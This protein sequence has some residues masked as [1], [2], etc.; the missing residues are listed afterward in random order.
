MGAFDTSFAAGGMQA[1]LDDIIKQ[2]FLQQIESRRAM[3][4]QQQH[5]IQQGQLGQ[6][7][8]RIDQGAAEF[9]QTMGLNRDKLGEDQRQFNEQA[10]TRLAG[11]AHTNAAT[12]ELLRKPQAELDER[13]FTTGRDTSQQ[14]FTTRR[15]LTQHGY[16]L[17]EIGAQNAGQLRAIAARSAA[18]ASP[19][20]GQLTPQ[21]Q[22]EVQDT[23]DLIDRLMSDPALNKSVGPLDAAVTK[24]D[25]TGVSGP[26]LNA[27][28][29]LGR[30]L[31]GDPAGVNRFEN[32]QNE[33]VG[34]LQLA[35]AGK[36]KGQG[37]VSDAERAMLARA[38]TSLSRN[39]SEA[40]YK[41]ELGRIR[42]QMERMGAKPAADAGGGGPV[43]M[44]APDG[45]PLSVPA[46][47]VAEMERLGAKRR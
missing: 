44:V 30:M 35:Q 6:G 46:E 43:S 7:Q 47:K 4:A 3:E 8:Q 20:A 29:G 23:A 9:G 36:L 28:G 31:T 17:G 5:A 45:R 24:T 15:D 34:K 1:S 21:Q 42:Q 26:I 11:V 18:E 14:N 19:A 22:N 12:G 25:H 2:K 13:A 32:T 27:A 10:P 33:L 37:A 40:D 41:A 16:Q 38:V 39:T